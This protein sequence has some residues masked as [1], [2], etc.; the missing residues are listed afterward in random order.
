MASD[1]RSARVALS[2]FAATAFL[3]LRR[4]RR[5]GNS[6]G[7]GSS[8]PEQLNG[9]V[10]SR[11]V[12]ALG[13]AIP[14]LDA[15]LKCLFDACDL[16]S[17]PRGHIALCM[18]ENKLVTE[19]LAQRLM[20]P[21]TA[22]SAFADSVV[23]SYNG[24]LGLPQA[25]EA[26]AYF[27]A[28]KFLGSTEKGLIDPQ[29]VAFGSGA[30]SLLNYLCFALAEE[31]D[32]VLIP[33]P[34][35]AA[36]ESDMAT[37]AKC[38]P[39]PIVQSDPAAG[40]TLSELNAAMSKAKAKGLR[41]KI[42][43]LTNPNNPIGTIY[44]PKVMKR[45]I[46]WARKHKLHTIVDEIYAL[47]VR[48]RDFESVLQ[49]MDNNLGNDVHFL[50]ALSKDFV[51]SGFRI[52]ILYTQN[53]ALLR[54]LQNLNIFSGVSHPMQLIAA[55]ILS[56]DGFVDSFLKTSREQLSLACNICGEKLNEMVVPHVIPEAGMFV[57]A[58]FSSLLPSQT[59]E[60]EERFAT[61]VQD[62]A[63]VVMTPGQ[64]MRDPRIGWFRICVAYY[65]DLDVLK[66]ALERLSRLILKIKGMGWENISADSVRAQILS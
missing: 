49:T 4:Q 16:V 14:Y 48:N 38:V 42:V 3:Y 24:F 31:G 66:V 39:F 18:A 23:Y 44:E 25:R 58:N 63:R 64:S 54:T 27:L 17:N 50:W 35:Y 65:P 34:Y 19:V 62:A 61:L 53:E 30:A 46:E 5:G 43:L 8:I 56:D 7:R 40:P 29:H 21:G 57:Y 6:V 41:P 9:R 36:F 45:T 26:V 37:I 2:A 22:A 28:R 20:S 33:A 15:F 32:A 10:G 11:G 12:A 47:S 51:S 60:G 52:G 59:P 1:N 13:P 55:E